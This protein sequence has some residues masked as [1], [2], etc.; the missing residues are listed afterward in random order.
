M[1]LRLA[2]DGLADIDPALSALVRPRVPLARRYGLLALIVLAAALALAPRATAATLVGVAVALY[3]AVTAH[4]LL[5]IR[6]AV[7]NDPTVEVTDAEAR[8]IRDADLPIYTV[9][10]PAYQE[11]EVLPRLI[12]G[13]ARLEYPLSLIHI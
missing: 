12:G 2:T 4:R 6:R 8:T 11:P 9:L 3:A 5:L 1:R 13:L 10:V 7:A